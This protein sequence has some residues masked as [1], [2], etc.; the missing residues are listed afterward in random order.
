MEYRRRASRRRRKTDGAPS[1]GGAVIAIIIVIA[2]V[3]FVATSNVGT[4]IAQN[5]FAPLFGDG[6]GD[7]INK[8]GD[9]DAEADATNSPGDVS[10]VGHATTRE[11]SVP[12]LECYMIQFGVF[13]SRD[14][15]AAQAEKIT[16]QGAAGYIYEDGER[17]RVLASGY[18][19]ESGAKSV[20]ERLVSQGYECTVFK[21]EVQGVSFRV[22]ADETLIDD[23]E[24]VFDTINAVKNSLEEDVVK[25]DTDRPALEKQRESIKN[26]MDDIFGAAAKLK[27]RGGDNEVIAAMV[28]CCGKFYES[29]NELFMLNTESFIDFSS[30][31]KYT[32]IKL[33]CEYA[34]LMEA[35]A[36]MS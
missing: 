26:M 31:M 13:K 34:R 27:D 20:K 3:Y 18:G 32:Q 10:A 14:N 4:W 35:L 25:F 21:L 7:V 16:S 12:A 17:F 19:S 28:D 9:N 2:M 30:K 24:G 11:V 33:T 6:S 22:T 29:L 15:A 1:G 8:R 36:S 5:V 23:V